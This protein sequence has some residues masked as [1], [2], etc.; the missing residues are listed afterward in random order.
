MKKHLLAL[1]VMVSLLASCSG[2]KLSIT[3]NANY[4][5]DHIVKIDDTLI[6]KADSKNLFSKIDL[7]RGEHTLKVDAGKPVTFEVKENGILNIAHQEFV[8]FPIKFSYGDRKPQGIVMNTS[9][10]VPNFVV[11]DSFVVGNPSIMK[12]IAPK[13]K[14]EEILELGNGQEHTEL[15]KT[16]SNQLVIKQDWDYD[17]NDEIPRSIELSVQKGIKSADDYRKKVLEA[18]HFM[19]YAVVTGAYVVHSLSE[20]TE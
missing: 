16:D 11:V 9:F 18:R 20:W 14:R 6:L 8:I 1:P 15:R 12:D 7:S 4:C 2:K 17:I 19:A 10:G 13:M 3:Y 5:K